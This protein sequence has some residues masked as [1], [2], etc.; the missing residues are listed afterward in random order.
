MHFEDAARQVLEDDS[1]FRSK[2]KRAEPSK[3]R[4]E[5]PAVSERGA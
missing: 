1:R 3:S 4:A 2:V 5:T